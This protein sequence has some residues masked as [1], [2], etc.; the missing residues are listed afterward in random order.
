LLFDTRGVLGLLVLLI[1]TGLIML[2]RLPFGVVPDISDVQVQMLAQLPSL[3][4]EESE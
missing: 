1:A 4:L 2:P 3:A